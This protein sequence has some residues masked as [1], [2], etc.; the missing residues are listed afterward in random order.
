MNTYKVQH[1]DGAGGEQEEEVIDADRAE[2]D[3]ERAQVRLWEGEDLVGLFQHV[4]G[5]RKMP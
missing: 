1:S 4:S 3:E 2:Y 5:F